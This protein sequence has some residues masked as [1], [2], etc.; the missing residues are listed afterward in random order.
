MTNEKYWGALFQGHET[1]GY[2]SLVVHFN[3][4]EI[5]V[6]VESFY[7]TSFSPNR[8]AFSIKDEEISVDLLV[9]GLVIVP[10]SLYPP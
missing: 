1:G 10:T 9:P 6:F 3:N 4:I 8:P 2:Y 7:Y 5:R